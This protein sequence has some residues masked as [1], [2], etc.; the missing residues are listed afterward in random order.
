MRRDILFEGEAITDS[1]GTWIS[2]SVVPRFDTTGIFRVQIAAH[3]LGLNSST[4]GQR[5]MFVYEQA[6]DE[7]GGFVRIHHVDPEQMAGTGQVFYSFIPTAS[8]FWVH[9]HDLYY[10]DSPESQVEQFWISIRAISDSTTDG[11]D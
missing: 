10:A 9:F 5:G 7:N 3:G 6:V 11:L 8:L 2:T 4:M 1:E